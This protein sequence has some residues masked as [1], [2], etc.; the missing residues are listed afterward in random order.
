M[1]QIKDAYANIKF[2]IMKKI[3]IMNALKKMKHVKKKVYIN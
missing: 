1:K 3:I 2:I